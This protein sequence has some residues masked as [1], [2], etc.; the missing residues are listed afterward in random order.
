V[1]RLIAFV[2]WDVF[3]VWRWVCVCTWVLSVLGVRA[4]SPARFSDTTAHRRPNENCL[5]RDFAR[6]RMRMRLAGC[7]L[8]PKRKHERAKRKPCRAS[9][10]PT[11]VQRKNRNA[12]KGAARNDRK[13]TP[14]RP[15]MPEAVP[16]ASI[17]LPRSPWLQS[18]GQASKESPS[19]TLPRVVHC[20]DKHNVQFVPCAVSAFA[21]RYAHA[22]RG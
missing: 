19:W 18:K 17:S 22:C 9:C 11:G 3:C 12:S 4:C 14:R 5:T 2:I 6:V 16:T 15:R 1:A 13:A 21:K 20:W 7:V 10:R 8:P